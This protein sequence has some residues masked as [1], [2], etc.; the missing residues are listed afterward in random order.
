[1]EEKVHLYLIYTKEF[2]SLSAGNWAIFAKIH[3]LIQQ[4]KAH[5]SKL[6]TLIAVYYPCRLLMNQLSLM[7]KL[8][9]EQKRHI[10]A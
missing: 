4:N 2:H 6:C 9:N 5:L 3:L 1:M 7:S 8:Q 10:S